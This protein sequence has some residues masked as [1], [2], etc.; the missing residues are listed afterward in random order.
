MD[1]VARAHLAQTA[2]DLPRERARDGLGDASVAPEKLGHVAAR[3]VLEHQEHALTRLILDDVQQRDDV[4][5]AAR[6]QDL[7]LGL[8]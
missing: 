1:E 5:V 3:A 7:D 8:Q 4:G 6:A 2:H